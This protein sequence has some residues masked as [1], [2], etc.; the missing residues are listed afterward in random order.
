MNFDGGLWPFLINKKIANKL[1]NAF[2]Y[3]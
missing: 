3:A 1:L 2:I